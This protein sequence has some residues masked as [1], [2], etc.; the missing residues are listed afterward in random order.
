MTEG[1]LIAGT[2]SVAFIVTAIET[3]GGK[4]LTLAQLARN[5]GLAIVIALGIGVAL[6]WLDRPSQ[7]RTTTMWPFIA[8][9]AIVIIC[10]IAA[11]LL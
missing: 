11:R 10:F 7:K 4:G 2:L 5:M 9:A 1:K 8:F 3:A 6:W